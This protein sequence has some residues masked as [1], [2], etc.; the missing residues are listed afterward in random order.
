MSLLRNP[1]NGSFVWLKVTVQGVRQWQ[2][3]LAE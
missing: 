2:W 1:V 3:L